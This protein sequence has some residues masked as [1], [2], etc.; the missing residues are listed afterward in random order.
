MHDAAGSVPCSLKPPCG[1]HQ[2]ARK[3][4][5]QKH[6]RSSPIGRTSPADR[7]PGLEPVNLNARYQT[8]ENRETQH[9]PTVTDHTSA[10][11][12]ASLAHPESAE[13]THM[14]THKL[15]AHRKTLVKEC[16]YSQRELH[17]TRGNDTSADR[18]HVGGSLLQQQAMET[19]TE[20]VLHP[21][22]TE[23]HSV[24]AGRKQARHN[25]RGHEESAVRLAPMEPRRAATHVH[26]VL[27]GRGWRRETRHS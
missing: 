2:W 1:H 7:W 8:D 10:S 23:E 6:R 25:G 4:K 11:H 20:G 22:R 27:L 21:S 24:R 14:R 9:Q 18:T 19:F 3:T 12:S 5:F 16:V 17:W 13:S 15:A 26:H